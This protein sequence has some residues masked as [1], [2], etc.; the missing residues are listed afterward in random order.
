MPRLRYSFFLPTEDHLPIKRFVL[1]FRMWFTDYGRIL[2]GTLFANVMVASVGL[3]ISAYLLSGFIVT[4]LIVTFIFSFFNRPQVRVERLLSP[5]PCAGEYYFYQVKVTN[6]GRRLLRD[7]KICEGVL[8]Y[9]LYDA[10]EHEKYSSQ[11]AWLNPQESAVITLVIRSKVRGIYILPHLLAGT[12]FPWGLLRWPVKA[13]QK[14][15]L[16]VYPSF[17]SQ[18][19][20]RVPVRRVHQPGGIAVSSHVGDSTEFLSTR[21][22]RKGDRLRDIHWA[23]Y[24]RSGRLIVKEYVDEYF[25][26]VGLLLDTYVRR[27][28][29]V[30]CFEKRI[31][32]AAGIADALAGRDYIIDLFAAGDVLHHF[33]MGRALAQL[34]NL[35]ELLACLEEMGP[36]S[37]PAFLS[38]LRWRPFSVLGHLWKR[39][40]EGYPDEKSRDLNF[41]K[42]KAGLAPYLG[43][44]SSVI[45]LLGDWDPVRSDLC[46]T[47]EQFGVSLRI[48]V[49]SSQPLT[50]KPDRELTVAAPEGREGFIR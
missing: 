3:Q 29:S 22:Y 47:L 17:V 15:R 23:S 25:V 12:S 1:L 45:V 16:V 14:D 42:L 5:F 31:S 50:L 4:L 44:L 8:P 33:Q 32:L 27:G 10:P 6:V 26:R 30:P 40:S 48:V 39:A 49:I 28:E 46:R 38:R 18:K 11:V 35:L 7:L 2:I 24:A 34:N 13:G 19:E 9:G 20:F 36:G 21:E 37:T 43:R 41:V